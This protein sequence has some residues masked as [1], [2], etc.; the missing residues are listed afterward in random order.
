MPKEQIID[1]IQLYQRAIDLFGKDAQINMVFEE[2]GELISK[3]SQYIR[4]RV[5][6]LE[7]AS[8]IADVEIMLAQLKMILNLEEDTDRIKID[9]LVRLIIKVEEHERKE[10]DKAAFDHSIKTIKKEG[11]KDGICKILLE[12]GECTKKEQEA[13]EYLDRKKDTL[14]CTKGS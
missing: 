8:E 1:T 5:H 3:L 7:V 2:T 9:K 11:E 10:K 6:V 13:C 4:G 12:A 14:Y